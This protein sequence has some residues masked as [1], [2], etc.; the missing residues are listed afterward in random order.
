[1]AKTSQGLDVSQMAMTGF[2]H[3]MDSMDLVKRAWTSLAT[4][5]T[6]TLN[7]GELDKRISDLRAVEQWLALNQNMLRST[8]QGLEIQRGTLDAFQTVTAGFGKAMKPADDSLAQTL[9]GFAA[10]A[11][12]KSVA[13]PPEPAAAPAAGGSPGGLFRPFD[14]SPFG[15]PSSLLAGFQMPSPA[16][17]QGD[18]DKSAVSG[19]DGESADGV[20]EGSSGA[21]AQP[22][23]GGAPAG[24]ADAASGGARGSEAGGGTDAAAD[25]AGAGKQPTGASSMSPGAM[26]PGM[27]P[28]AWWEMLQANFRQIAQ[29][30]TTDLTRAA[31]DAVA[32]A[33]SAGGGGSSST[34]AADGTAGGKSDGR[35]AAGSASRRKSAGKPGATAAAGKAGD[36][37]SKTAAKATRRKPRG[38]KEEG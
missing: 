36:G 16:V 10:A 32:A 23:S 12:Q 6:P 15:M 2:G 1:V 11:A 24:D 17:G 13:P 8:I 21:L 38:A 26:P 25:A 28:L 33:R 34:G 19:S 3:M 20:K 29:A 5:F 31:S 9:A 30:A 4:P 27:N 35:G 14:W 22:A 7:V 37:S 18:T